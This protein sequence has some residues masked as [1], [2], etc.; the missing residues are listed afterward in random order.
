MD[1]VGM[2]VFNGVMIA[3]AVFALL[4]LIIFTAVSVICIIIFV[5]K[6]NRGERATAPAVIAAIAISLAAFNLFLTL[7]LGGI[8]IAVNVTED[9][10]ITEDLYEETHTIDP[11]Q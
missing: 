8:A 10:I 6:D 5:K 11:Y 1:A 7:Y 9:I 4:G 2:S 3:L